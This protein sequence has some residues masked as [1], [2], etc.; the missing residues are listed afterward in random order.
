M[1]NIT[2]RPTTI[3]QAFTLVWVYHKV[4]NHTHEVKV[5]DASFKTENY[6]VFNIRDLLQE[7]PGI[8]TLP[9]S[10]EELVNSLP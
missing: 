8:K 3:M 10:S 9:I 6:F 2:E 4:N 7:K 1:H 5:T